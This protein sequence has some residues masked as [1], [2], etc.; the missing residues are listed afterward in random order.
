MA[1]ALVS[2]AAAQSAGALVADR[3]LVQVYYAVAVTALVSVAAAQSAV[4]LAAERVPVQVHHAV[5]A[6]LVYVAAA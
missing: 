4:A 3:V 2:V 5:V 1:A 6:A